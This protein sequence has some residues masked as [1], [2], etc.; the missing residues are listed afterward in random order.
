MTRCRGLGRAGACLLV[1]LF[2]AACDSG[3]D[4]APGEITA[5]VVSPNGAE[6]SAVLSL[7]GRGLE[8]VSAPEGWIYAEPRGDTLR[9][10]YVRDEPGV[11]SFAVR[12]ADTT[13]AVSAVVEEV[14]GPDDALRLVTTGYTV[15]F[16]R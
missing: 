5:T 15:T 14:A 4:S 10:V 3:L 2:L 1:I 6:G 16:A 7:H 9:V 11:L 13:Q 12:M 8:G